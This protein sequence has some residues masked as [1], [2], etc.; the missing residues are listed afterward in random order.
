MFGHWI[1]GKVIASP[2]EAIRSMILTASGS[3]SGTN[4]RIVKP[5]EAMA[6]A[7]LFF[8]FRGSQRLRDESRAFNFSCMIEY[9][10]LAREAALNIVPLIKIAMDVGKRQA[11]SSQMDSMPLGSSAAPLTTGRERR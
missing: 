3:P 10:H 2:V 6:P 4:I 1:R 9:L 11:L 8:K 5:S 7:H